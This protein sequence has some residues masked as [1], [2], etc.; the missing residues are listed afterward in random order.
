M[1]I[2]IRE[3]DIRADRDVLIETLHRFLNPLADPRRFDW[4]YHGNPHGSARSWLAVESNDGSIVGVASAFPRRIYMGEKKELAWVLGDFCINSNY[5]ALGPALKLQRACL[6]AILST[7]GAFCYDLPNAGMAAVYKRLQI[8]PLG[9]MIR[10]ARPLRLDASIGRIVKNS[11]LARPLSVVANCL[12]RVRDGLVKRTSR[13]LTINLHKG[14]CGDEFSGL[15]SE[16]NSRYGICTERSAEYLNWRYLSNTYCRYD[17]VTARR[18]GILVA[19]AMCHETDGHAILADLFG[20]DDP[21][22]IGSLVEE[23]AMMVRDKG[24]PTLSAPLF[25]SHPWLPLLQRVGFWARE[26]SPVMIYPLSLKREADGSGWFLTHG[27]RDS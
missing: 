19:Y 20:I 21:E 9:K 2:V 7:G 17:L 12:L 1:A 23:V 13:R 8:E 16:V 24:V 11:T 5:R 22:V 15:A 4:L 27:D 18:E 25:E 3:A 6:D 10:L 26:S 14:E